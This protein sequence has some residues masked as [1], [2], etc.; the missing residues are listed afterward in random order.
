MTATASVSRATRSGASGKSI[1]YISC[2]RG[3]PPMPI[4]STNRPPLAI[5][6][7]DAIRASN[8]GWRFMTLA[9]KVPTVA[10]EVL[11]AAI[12]RIV[13]L[14]TTGT[15]SSPRPTKWSQAQRPA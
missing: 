14:S 9:T 13:Q 11:A 12:D 3:A 5:W 10:C 6:S 7:V 8:A 4:P 15:V 1:P 2:S